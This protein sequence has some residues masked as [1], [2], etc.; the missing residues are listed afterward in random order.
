MSKNKMSKLIKDILEVTDNVLGRP[1]T[2]S[3]VIQVLE[4]IESFDTPAKAVVESTTTIVKPKRAYRKNRSYTSPKV[5]VKW[6]ELQW[7]CDDVLNGDSH[8]ISLQDLSALVP[9]TEMRY[10]AF[11]NHMRIEAQKR[12][13]KTAFIRKDKNLGVVNIQAVK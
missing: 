2:R 12:G 6:S 1:A 5:I 10:E 3:Q 8:D 4:L 11:T 13:Y 9:I 7:W